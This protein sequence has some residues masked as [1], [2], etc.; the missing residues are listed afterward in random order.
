M[1]NNNLT[2]REFLKTLPIAVGLVAY[3]LPDSQSGISEVSTD[4]Y[5]KPQRDNASDDY[6]SRMHMELMHQV[7][8]AAILNRNNPNFYRPKTIR[9]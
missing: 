9:N 2:R 6:E 7:R 3:R 4:T 8:S 1:S 5:V